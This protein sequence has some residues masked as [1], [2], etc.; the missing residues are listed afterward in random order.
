MYCGYKKNYR[1]K[2]IAYINTFISETFGPVNIFERLLA[3]KNL[4]QCNVRGIY[5]LLL[6]PLED[7]SSSLKHL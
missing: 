6:F 5:Y 3:F 1:H 7:N 4:E 2:S